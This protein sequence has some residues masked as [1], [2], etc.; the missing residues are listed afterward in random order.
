M[1]SGVKAYIRGAGGGGGSEMKMLAFIRLERVIYLCN[2]VLTRSFTST[3]CLI[4]K[5]LRNSGALEPI[6][7]RRMSYPVLIPC[8]A[9]I[10][11]D[12]NQ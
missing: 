8:L 5:K 4:K 3:R 11:C 2:C 9:S 7:G 6:L 10:T 12:I 1:L